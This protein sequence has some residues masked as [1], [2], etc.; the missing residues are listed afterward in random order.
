[1]TWHAND[2][3][4]QNFKSLVCLPLWLLYEIKCSWHI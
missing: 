1:M 2:L 4:F 3:A